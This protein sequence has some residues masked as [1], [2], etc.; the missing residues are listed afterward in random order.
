MAVELPI[1]DSNLCSRS[2]ERY[3]VGLATDMVCAGGTKGNR[4]ACKGDSGG[5]MVVEGVLAGLTAWGIGCGQESTP[6]A[7]TDLAQ[8]R[9]WIS[10]AAAILLKNADMDSD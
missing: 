8:Y 4:D 2:M 1:V 6:G 3:G 5:P 10:Q 7:Y 9:T